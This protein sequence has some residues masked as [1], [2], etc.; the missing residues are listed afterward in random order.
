MVLLACDGGASAFQSLEEARDV[1]RGMH[2]AE[3]MD[4]GSHHPQLEQ[5]RTLLPGDSTQELHEKPREP[6]VNE[7]GPVTG[8]PDDV[9]VEAVK[10]TGELMRTGRTFGINSSQGG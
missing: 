9:A 5:V 10:H 6:D 4:M 7:W 8:R 1:R 2:A 3:E